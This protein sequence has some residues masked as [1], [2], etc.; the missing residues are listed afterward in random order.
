MKFNWKI[1]FGI[2]GRHLTTIAGGFTGAMGFGAGNL[3]VMGIG[4]VLSILGM[5]FSALEKST[6][7]VPQLTDGL[8]S[9]IIEK[10]LTSVEV[11]A[12]VL[13]KEK[14]LVPTKTP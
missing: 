4:L 9:S 10:V 12:M 5:V 3:W 8:V 6:P 2:L 13:A 7:N 11:Q 1:I 14:G